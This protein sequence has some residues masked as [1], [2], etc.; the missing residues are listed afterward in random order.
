[1]KYLFKTNATMKEYNR[2]N[3]YIDR[4][5][6]RDKIIDAESF[7]IA[8]DKYIEEINKEHY[9]I[10]SKNAVKNKQPIYIDTK[11]GGAKQVGFCITASTIFDKGNYRGWSKQYFDLWVEMLELKDI[12]FEEVF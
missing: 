2:K 12:D 3:W 9:D 7:K 5:Y 1:M 10:V 6:I 4:D 11:D 8:F